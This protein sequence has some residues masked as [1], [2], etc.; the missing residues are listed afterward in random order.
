[1]N[2]KE[3]YEAPFA[4]V[5]RLQGVHSILD[6]LSINGT[7]TDYEAGGELESTDYYP[8]N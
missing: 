8:T 4:E 5:F 7:A 3:H 6:D 1:M 2:T